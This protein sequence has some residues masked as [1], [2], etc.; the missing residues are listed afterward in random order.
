MKAMEEMREKLTALDYLSN[1]RGAKISTHENQIQELIR[2]LEN[3]E[4]QS[5]ILKTENIKLAMGK[6]D[7]VETNKQFAE[8]K[9]RLNEHDMGM[10]EN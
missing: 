5:D 4:S 6:C 1:S 7:I 3:L 8:I 2:R 10:F 9:E